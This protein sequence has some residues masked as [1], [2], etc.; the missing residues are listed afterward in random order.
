[1]SAAAR[2]NTPSPAPVSQDRERRFLPSREALETFLRAAASWTRPCVYDSGLPFAFTRT[3]YFDTE[4]L[5]FLDSCRHGH[6]QRLRLREYAGT[7]DLAQ[8]AVLTGTRYLELKT[9]R[10][11]Q[12]TKVRAPI[13][14]DEASAL[15][16]GAEL[17]AN[18]AAARLLRDSPHGPVRPWV[19]AW[20]RRGTLANA[21]ASVRITVDEDLVFAL[22]PRDSRLGVPAA[23]TRLIQQ[24]PATLVE[25]KG[26]GPQPA[27]LE[28]ALRTL[29][30][31]ETH[32]SKFE[33][34]MRALLDGVPAV[35]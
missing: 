1:M 9:N 30:A 27:W 14:S 29:E 22:P 5:D 24:A 13:T 7:A 15:L 19:M 31:F 16:G 25:V 8:P 20:Y 12:R 3:T 11:E 35:K 34:G 28:E 33:Q 18:G 6:T 23:P 32:D 2:M 21:D 26:W 4:R 10:G 17:P